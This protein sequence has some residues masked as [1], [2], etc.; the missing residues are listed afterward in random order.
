MTF[1]FWVSLIDG[2]PELSLLIWLSAL[3]IVMYIARQPAH[4]MILLLARSLRNALRLMAQSVML[5]ERQLRSRNREVLLVQGQV[6]AE[7][8][9]ERE[10][11]R[12]ETL[13][14]RDLSG[15]PSLQRDL[16]EQIT[17][18][19][20]DYVQSSEVPPKPP[21]WLKA[22][23]AVADIPDNG[24][25]VVA[26]ILND[27]HSTLKKALET[28]LQ[29]YRRANR[30]RHGLLKKMM[31]YWRS[32]TNSL[33]SVETKITGL[34]Q[35]SLILDE[36]MKCYEDIRNQTDY[37][38]RMLSSSSMT[39]FFISGLALCLAII[40]MY[41][42]FQLV[43]LPM[44]EMVGASSYLGS[45]SIRASD[46]SALFIISIEV[47]LGLFLME[48]VGVTRLFPVIHLL[49]DHK[50]K[51]I[52]WIM[53]S[54]L[55]IFAGIEASLAYMRDMLAAD[56][57]ALSQLLTGVEVAEPPLRWIPSVGQMV[58]GFTLPFVLT[59]VAI[60]LESF[61]H[62]F[63]TVS[64][65]FIV[66]VLHMLVVIIRFVANVIYG[67][68]RLLMSLYDLIIFIPLK[69]EIS[70]KKSAVDKKEKKEEKISGVL[71]HQKEQEAEL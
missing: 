41:V 24:S 68:G 25:P 4:Q 60:P 21:E 69:L 37:A 12:V 29:E 57:E 54:F 42:N 17:R 46:V 2:Q 47:I 1:D 66:W 3:V 44:E 61:I 49:E 65:L 27:I 10:F 30:D 14:N 8:F 51:I 40:G 32:L 16:K 38:V 63:R 6:H 35:R 67:I 7:R 45:S 22:V 39:Q 55:F 53:L 50:R 62:S 43:A 26:K 64:G 5:A 20:E 19:D 11:Q 13:V 9:I 34:E 70:V 59:F 58:M 36:Q 28:D 23:E 31:P 56:R 15:Y 71:T 33:N 52:F 18:I 48:S